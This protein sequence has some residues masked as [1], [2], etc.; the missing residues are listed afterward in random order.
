MGK[1]SKIGIICLV[2][3]STFLSGCYG[4]FALTRKVYQLNGEVRDKYLRSGV[5]WAFIF[6]PVYGVSALLDFVVFNTIEFWNGQ[7]PIASGE[8]TMHFADQSGRYDI[9]AVK[10][11]GQVTYEIQR[12]DGDG[13]KESMNIRW[14]LTT[15]TSVVRV[16]QQGTSRTYIA[17][18]TADG[19]V[20]VTAVQPDDRT[21]VAKR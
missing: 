1:R 12:T 4:K 15:G 17:A 7:N 21:V 6:V 14:D 2:L 11:N 19:D 18:K 20:K 5:T 10:K 9:H 8:K 3:A 16:D 13:K